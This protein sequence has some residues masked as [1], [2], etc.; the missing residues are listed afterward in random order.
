MNATQWQIIRGILVKGHQVASGQALDSPYPYGTIEKQ[1]SLFKDLGLDLSDFFRGTLNISIVP[2]TWTMLNPQWT[3]PHLEWT[4]LHPPETFSFS[5]C[6]VRFN[7]C[8]YDS[9]IYYPH[10]KTKKRHFQAPSLIEIIAPPIEGIKQGE[11]IQIAYNP[12]E[13]SIHSF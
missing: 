8:S 6:Q 9:W 5:A 12:L 10:P 11:I 7:Q 2:K 3:F 1:I 4:D 13:I